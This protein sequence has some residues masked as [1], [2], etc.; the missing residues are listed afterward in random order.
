VFAGGGPREQTG[1]SPIIKPNLAGHWLRLDSES[2]EGIPIPSDFD[3][4]GWQGAMVKS[5]PHATDTLE[6]GFSGRIDLQNSFMI[7]GTFFRGRD[8]LRVGGK[9]ISRLDRLGFSIIIVAEQA[10]L[11]DD[12][13][14]G[15]NL[16]LE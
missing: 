8:W 4:F 7:P 6:C 14:L 16:M 3:L 11:L 12:K 10:L 5:H 13:L 1:D 15:I 2:E 9:D